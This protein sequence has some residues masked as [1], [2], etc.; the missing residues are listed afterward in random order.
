MPLLS[1]VSAAIA[2]A[3][4]K[5]EPV[6]LSALRMLKAA[7]MNREIERGRALDGAKSAR[8]SPP[9]SSGVRIPSIGSR[10]AAARTWP[11]EAAEIVVLEATCRR[12]PIRPKS[13]ALWPR[14][15]SRL[16]PRRP[17][18][19]AK[20][21]KAAMRTAG[22]AERRREGRQRAGAEEAGG[23]LNFSGPVRLTVRDGSHTT[24]SSILL[25]PFARTAKGLFLLRSGLSACPATLLL[26]RRQFS[27][28]TRAR[29][30]GAEG[31]HR[32][33]RRDCSSRQLA[34][35]RS[36]TAWD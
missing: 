1:D 29:F 21:M 33:E 7:L 11:K 26:T 25:W 17:K 20:W 9:W 18:T 8:S 12:P 15:W 19:W 2:D 23:R 31:A 24:F 14:R 28:R 16:A 34:L 27:F 32:G 10:L 3:M 13:N 36:S 30:D 35:P 6:R 5:Q 4:R 22:R